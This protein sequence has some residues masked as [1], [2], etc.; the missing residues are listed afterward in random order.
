MKT[1]LELP[2]ELFAEA[3]LVAARR[4]TTLKAL[5]THALRR[6]LSPASAPTKDGFVVDA[7]GM[8]HL[9]KRG[10][11][12]TSGMVHQLLDDEDSA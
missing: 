11:R 5:F 12:V 1:T 3:K 4:R 2:D 7:D 6:E 9:P 8:P 10:A